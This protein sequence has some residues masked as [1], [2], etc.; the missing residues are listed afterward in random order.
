MG[1]G[2]SSLPVNDDWVRGC[3]VSVATT[4][5]LTTAAEWAVQE[6]EKRKKSVRGEKKQQQIKQEEPSFVW[7]IHIHGRRP[8]CPTV[9]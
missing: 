8:L 3:L 7:L 6:T 5:L 2:L 9:G 1:R 4:F